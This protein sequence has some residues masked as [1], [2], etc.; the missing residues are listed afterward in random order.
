MTE[1]FGGF[2]VT[3]FK[4]NLTS[5]QLTKL[6]L[7]ERQL[8]AVEYVKE[9]GKITNKE[10]Q[11]LNNTIDRTALRYLKNLITLGI[12][13]RVGEKQGAYYELVV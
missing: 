6:G 10:Y 13:K 7:N 12:F 5:E 3:L 1:E 4:N 11:E 9:K 2:L 8:K